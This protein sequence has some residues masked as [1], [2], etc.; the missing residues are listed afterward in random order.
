MNFQRVAKVDTADFYLDIAIK[1]GKA[2]VEQLPNR[3]EP[4][5]TRARKKARKFVVETGDILIGKLNNIIKNYPSFNTLP[6]FYKELAKVTLELDDVRQSLGAIQWA[7]E[8]VDTFTRHYKGKIGASKE[9]PDMKFF[10][11]E[12]IGRISSVMKQ[13]KK[14]FPILENARKT[15]K[16]YPDVKELPTLVIAG[17]PNVGK[18]TLL[19]ALTT[20]APKIASY[21]FTTL[22]PMLGTYT[23]HNVTYQVMDT[24]GMLDRPLTHMNRVE[25]QAGLALQHLAQLVIFVLDP[26]ELCG[27]SL[28]EQQALL[29]QIEKHFKIPF[30]VVANKS[31]ISEKLADVM[32]ISAEKNTGIATLRQQ[33]AAVYRQLE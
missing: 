31:D 6:T 20:S 27:Y 3:R 12:Y 2:K 32:N 7:A 9:V 18:T 26:T 25:K 33:V 10:Q 4:A 29:A 13:I 22:R 8:S 16:N 19:K 24:P 30:I 23:H 17:Y 11:R 5:S 28:K 15:M 21:P 1:R 14:S